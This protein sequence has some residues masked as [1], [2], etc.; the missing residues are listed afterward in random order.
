LITP[1]DLAKRF[2]PFSSLRSSTEAFID[3]CLPESKPK[4][5]YA[6][7]GPG[8]SQNPTSRST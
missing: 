6:L 5:N 8:V 2:I 7:V 3:Y 4:F 1:A